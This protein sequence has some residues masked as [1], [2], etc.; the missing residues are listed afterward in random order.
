TKL[1]PNLSFL[2][3]HLSIF[4]SGPNHKN[5]FIFSDLTPFFTIS[6]IFVVSLQPISTKRRCRHRQGVS[7]K[8][9]ENENNPDHIHPR[10]VRVRR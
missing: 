7:K 4:A 10:A 6:R 3:L 9:K 2:W 5:P 1:C 8:D